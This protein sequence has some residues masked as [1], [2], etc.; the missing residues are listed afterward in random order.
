MTI[1]E[2]FTQGLLLDSPWRVDMS[3]FV[4]E[5]RRLVLHLGLD[6]ET[7]SL[8]CPGCGE[9]G[10]AI[11]DRRE[12][13]WRHLNFW[14]Y[15]TLIHAEVPRV[16][17]KRC[18]VRQAEVPWARPGSGF[19]LLF[20]A[21]V[22]ELVRHMPVSDAAALVGVYDKRIWTIIG[23]YV[24]KAYQQSDWGEVGRVAIDE[25]SRRKGHTYVTNFVDLDT[26]R[27]LFM[28]EGKEAETVAQFAGQ[29]ARFSGDPDNI[30]EA[31]IDMGGAYKKGVADHLPNAEV[32]FDRFHVAKLAGDAFDKVRKEVN[33]EVGGL[34]R[35]GMWALRGDASRLGQD[36]R[37]L[38]EEL[39]RTYSKLQRAMGLREMLADFYRH[40]DVKLAEGHFEAWYNWARRCRLE[41]FKRLAKTLLDHWAGIRAYYNNHTTSAIIE[42]LNGR[43]QRARQ[44]AYGYRSFRN[45]QLISYWIAGGLSPATGLASP[46]PE[47][48]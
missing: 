30:T 16:R 34:G 41:P 2:L 8:P 17:R 31:A 40:P 27:L 5:P 10:C 4:G 3:S 25:T 22:L 29:L 26:G 35:G 1:D 21:F 19:T 7:R 12:R 44:R 42:N 20:E 15:E 18:G 45:F 46:L 33:A 37:R 14:Q 13:T 48:F 24:E 9:A 43:I 6:G 28:A 36:M 32:V 39:L 47:T 38:R 23:H 11:H